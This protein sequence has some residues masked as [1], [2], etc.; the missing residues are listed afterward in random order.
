MNRLVKEESSEHLV[1]MVWKGRQG[2]GVGDGFGQAEQEGRR[3]G[4][5]IEHCGLLKVNAYPVRV[6]FEGESNVDG[7][8][9]EDGRS[10]KSQQI[11]RHVVVVSASNVT[12]LRG[13][14]PL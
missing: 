8:K 10:S 4:Y 11:Q 6:W 12:K 14:Q 9:D 2:Y 5:R 1:N 13:E 3:R 7:S